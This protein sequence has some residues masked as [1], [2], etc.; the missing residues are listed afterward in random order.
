MMI[1]ATAVN[2]K[3]RMRKWRIMRG[4]AIMAYLSLRIL[5]KSTTRR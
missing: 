3:G 1:K 5:L 2:R 4:A